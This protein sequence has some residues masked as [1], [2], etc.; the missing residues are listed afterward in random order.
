[1]VPLDHCVRIMVRLPLP[2]AA[3]AAF[4]CLPVFSWEHTYD[5]IPG[6]SKR[7]NPLPFDVN[8]P[9]ISPQKEF[10]DAS[11]PF[12]ARSSFRYGRQRSSILVMMNGTLKR[13]RRRRR[14]GGWYSEGERGIDKLSCLFAYFPLAFF[15]LSATAD[16]SAAYRL[17][18]LRLQVRNAKRVCAT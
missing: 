11:P 8:G 14:R 18:N 13:R 15:A 10:C 1:M 5:Y 6:I 12:A 17:C 4:V 2:P 7:Q 3:C 9:K 16:V